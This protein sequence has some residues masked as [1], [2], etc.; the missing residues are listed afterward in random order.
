MITDLTSGSPAGLLIK[1]SLP[2]LLS[3]VFQQL[4]NIIDSIIAGKFISADALAAVG[5]GYPVTMIFI[6]IATGCN[7]GCSVVISQLFG[8][9]NFS[10]LKCAAFTGIISASVLSLALT[11][12]GIYFCRPLLF[13]LQTP[14]NIFAD[15]EIYLN[16]YICGLIFVFLYNIAN[17]VF[18]ALGDSRTPLYFLIV[19]S[20]GN[21]GADLLFVKVFNMGVA[22]VAWAT[23]ICQA[24][25]AVLAVMVLLSKILRLPEKKF[26]LFSGLMLLKLLKISIPSILQQSFISVGNLFIQGLVN[27]FS[28]VVVAGYTAAIKLNTFAIMGFSTMGNALSSFSAQNLGANKPYRVQSAF[29]SALIMTAVIVLPFSIIYTLFAPQT[30]GIFVNEADAAVIAEGV[31]FLRIVAPF[32]IVV[33]VKLLI[34]GILRGGGS[35]LAFMIATFTDLILR[36]VIAFYLTPRLNS[37]VAI[38]LSWPVGWVIATILSALFYFSGCWKKHL[39]TD[40]LPSDKA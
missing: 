34:D 9:K 27:S 31:R 21:I 5:A 7:I 17:G 23:F 32:Y 40:G 28:S 11:G 22:G 30:V 3:V 18:V 14:A 4:Y 36:V 19:S 20:L 26:R 1:F 15:S 39:I 6:A 38:W 12:I 8:S 13:A 37:P 16:I 35:M 24:V 33:A 25:A 29:R 2:M 10:S